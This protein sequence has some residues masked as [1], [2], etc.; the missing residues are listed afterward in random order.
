MYVQVLGPWSD[1]SVL[2]QRGGGKVRGL[3]ALHGHG[4]PVPAWAVVGSDA[5]DA[6]VAANDLGGLVRDTASATDVDLALAAAARLRDALAAARLPDDVTA[7]IADAYR[8]AGAGRVAVRSSV[9]AEDGAASSYAGQFDTYLDVTG[10]DRVVE[11]VRACWASAF[12]DR[13][14]S[15]GFAHGLRAVPEVAV[16]VQALVD[17]DAAGVVFTLNPATG[18]ADEIVVSAIYGLGAPLVS[19]EVDADTITVAADATGALS[20]TD[21]VVGEKDSSLRP[22]SGEGAPRSEPVADTARG[23]AALT[24]QQTLDLARICA[25]FAAAAGEPQ[26]IEW[27][28][29]DG[30]LWFLQSRPI[31]ASAAPVPGGAATASGTVVPGSVLRGAGEAVPDGEMRIWDNS[32]I[33]ESFNGITSPLTYT[34]AADIYGR[35]YRGYARSL[36]VPDAQLAQ[37]DAWT[38][39]MLGCFHGRVYYNLLHWYRMVGIAP[40]YPLNRK[41]LEAALGVAEP[42][43]DDIA[44]ALR[45]FT[46]DTVGQ[47]LRSRGATTVRYAR[48]LRRIDAIVEDF[49]REFYRVYDEFERRDLSTMSGE[50]AY[51]AYR[52][53]DGDLVAR[54]GPLM[55]LDAILL[56]LTGTMY[57]LTK[58]FLPRAPEWFLYAVVGPGADVESAEPARAMTALAERAAADPAVRHLV[59]TADPAV[60]HDELDR[61]GHHGFRAA[62]DDYLGRYGYRSLDELKL[63]VPDLREDPSSVYVMLRSALGRAVDSGSAGR[64]TSADGGDDTAHSAQQYLDAHLHGV[65]RRIYDAVRAKTARCAAHRERLR[66]CRTRAFGMVKRLIR[67]LGHDLAERGVIDEFGDVFELTIDELRSCYR[68]GGDISA[69]PDDLRDVVRT[70]R[71][72]RLH[73][74]ALMAPERFVTHGSRFDPAELAAQGWV[75]VADLPPAEPGA[76]LVGTPSSAGVV[77][78]IARVVTEP[79]DVQGGVLVAYRTDPGWVAALPSASALVIERGSPL[80][81]VAIVA[82]ELGVPTVVQLRDATA[83]LRTGMRVRVDGTQGTVTVLGGG[84]SDAHA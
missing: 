7:A 10:I 8:R 14:I 17:A 53:V 3:S 68:S 52:D 39:V 55:V 74:A 33:I 23:R 73:D 57:L 59:E 84:E 76:M 18:N 54:W 5:F 77:D 31:T 58:A 32:N 35:V 50:E 34:T 63:E 28:L 80:T 51:A 40:G 48:R 15:Y 36:G 69:R 62:V 1:A 19:G 67:V 81:H 22:A 45:P 21:T 60:I 64:T 41:V 25:D 26:D 47:R 29:A 12:S 66:F 82:R 56:T 27:A 4:L 79:H 70:R 43:P 16:I 61:S 78:G 46:F 11:R 44:K 65:R 13:S 83:R 49:L 2:A 75:P 6:V 20:I 37:T 9:A 30:R 24:E 72:E 71:G 38:P 42:L